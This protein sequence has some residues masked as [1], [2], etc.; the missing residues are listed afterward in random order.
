MTNDID[1]LVRQQLHDVVV[2]YA[3][4]IDF[5]DWDLF[6]TCFTDDCTSSYEGIGEWGSGD[7]ITEFMERV[8][9]DCG[10]TMHWIGNHT[11]RAEGDGYVTRSYVA[12]VVMRGDDKKGIEHFGYYDDTFVATDDGWKIARRTFTPTYRRRMVAWPES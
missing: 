9:A 2:R 4:G 3:T 8:H 6:R 7:E 12:A 11:V 5:R 1:P 10:H